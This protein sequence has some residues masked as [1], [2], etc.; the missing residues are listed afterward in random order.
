MPY[1]A[2]SLVF[3]F[4]LNLLVVFSLTFSQITLPVQACKPDS[5]QAVTQIP[6]QASPIAPAMTTETA[7]AAQQQANS[8]MNSCIFKYC[9]FFP[10]MN[11]SSQPAANSGSDLSLTLTADLDSVEPGAPLVYTLHF[12]NNGPVD[13]TG[14]M[15]Y[16]YLPGSTTFRPTGSTAGWQQV[17]NSSE[18]ALAIS[19][20][21]AGAKGEA[22]FAVTVADL[23]PQGLTTIDNYAWIA[24]DNSNR[25]DPNLVNNSA[26][27]SIPIYFPQ[28]DLAIMLSD[29]GSAVA[30]GG[31][32]IYTLNYANNGD[33][34]SSGVII[35]ETLPAN[36]SFNAADSTAGWQQTGGSGPFTLSI[37][38]LSIGENG[39]A[40]FAVTVASSL[41]PGTTSLSDA[42]SISDDG[43]HGTDKN[44]ADNTSTITTLLDE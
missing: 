13:A 34:P 24:D 37:G 6:T 4:L 5:A 22:S 44:P 15:L 42:A 38:S 14:I 7:P 33:T 43:S 25:P 41:P 35:T 29:G 36:T 9:I 3:R 27:L 30:P 12:K 11:S 26:S 10:I 39:S 1:P 31:E 20:L 16:E 8:A 32:V 2:K 21:A 18:Y 28:P 17:G 40:K 23:V 19:W